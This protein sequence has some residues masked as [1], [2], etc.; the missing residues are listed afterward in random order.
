VD[1]RVGRVGEWTSAP[2]ILVEKGCPAFSLISEISGS[3]F[4]S[5]VDGVPYYQIYG[6]LFLGGGGGDGVC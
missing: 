6:T 2:Q 1:C 5:R 3:L 4:C